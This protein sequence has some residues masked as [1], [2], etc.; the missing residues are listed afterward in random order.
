MLFV[1]VKYPKMRCAHVFSS[2]VYDK[3]AY[4]TDTFGPRFSGSS[5]LERALDWAKV[6]SAPFAPS[7]FHFSAIAEGQQE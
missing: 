4:M 6:S 5:T 7:S 3:L 2:I 1:Y